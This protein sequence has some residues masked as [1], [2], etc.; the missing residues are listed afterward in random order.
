MRAAIGVGVV[1][2]LAM[3]T[4]CGKK[5]GKDE[6]AGSG[7]AAAT[8]G[9]A[10]AGTGGTAGS[11][12][13]SAATPAEPVKPMTQEQLGAWFAE[14]WG[15]FNTK[16]WDKF[17]GCYADDAV[18][19]G[20][21]PLKGGDAIVDYAKGFATAFPD[22]TGEQQL[23]LVNGTQI[24]AVTLVR[25]THSGPLKGPAGEV[26]ATNKKIGML[27]V[28]VIRANGANKA[29]H[30][31]LIMDS[32]TMMGQLGVLPKDVPFRAE[33]TAGWPEKQVVVAAG[34]GTE[35]QNLQ[36]YLA[37]VE[38]FNKHDAKALA[39]L[40]AD[41]IVWSE[42]AMPKDQNKLEMVKG[43]QGMWAA[44]SDLRLNGGTAWAAGPYVIGIGVMTGTN[45]G[46]LE[47]MG[48]D[49]TGKKM[50]IP[51]VEINRFKDGKVDRAWVF[52][53][54]AIMAAQLGLN[55]PPPAK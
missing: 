31:T 8:T 21:P 52:Y 39:D 1:C 2:A 3:G 42:V 35:S 15:F 36:K 30:E 47:M 26:P 54:S 49:K 43:V 46:K 29:Q 14:C 17:R 40:I 6:G 22:M 13:G 9:S 11:A 48:R 55:T 28:Q 12:T 25:G 50:E 10:T 7:T 38:A 27:V 37:S 4:A 5:K 32:A 20:P 44:F 53:D 34:D 33:L 24:V 41:D 16:A 45:D 51:Y 23:T 18:H 19:D